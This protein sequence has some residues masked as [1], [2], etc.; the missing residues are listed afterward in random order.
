MPIVANRRYFIGVSWLFAI[1][2]LA[3][4]FT[5]GLNFGVDFNGGSI[6]EVRSKTGPVDIGKL[7]ELAGGLG[8]WTILRST[9]HANAI[10]GYAPM[11]GN[12]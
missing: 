3:L 1:L 8:W 4:M 2:A 5:K 12:V 9:A 7:R 6:V 11:R 10:F